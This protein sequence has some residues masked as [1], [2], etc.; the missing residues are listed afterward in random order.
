MQPLE[1]VWEEGLC[2]FDT[3]PNPECE[4]YEDEE[5]F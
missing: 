1:C 3:C 2:D 5:D 4:Y